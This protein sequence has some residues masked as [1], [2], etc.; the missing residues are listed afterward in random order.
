MMPC[1]DICLAVAFEVT[2]QIVHIDL[3]FGSGLSPLGQVAEVCRWSDFRSFGC[4]GKN[5]QPL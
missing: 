5:L 4:N 3:P 1:R 2:G